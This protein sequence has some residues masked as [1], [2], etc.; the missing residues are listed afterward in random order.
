VTEAKRA[1]WTDAGAKNWANESFLITTAETVRYCVRTETGCWY[2]ADHEVL[3]LDEAKTVVTV[4]EAFLDTYLPIITQRL[5][6]AGI[7][8]GHLLNRALGG[9]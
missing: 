7:R 1:A 6:Q 3:D 2:A 9:E 4:D 5:T 8:L